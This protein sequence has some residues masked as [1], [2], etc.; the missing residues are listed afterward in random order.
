[1]TSPPKPG[2]VVVVCA[3]L[4]ISA[5]LVLVSG[6]L[7]AFAHWDPCSVFSGI[8]LLSLP[9]ALGLFQYQAV[10]RRNAKAARRA[11]IFL[12]IVAGIALLSL[13]TTTG[14]IFKARENP[15]S[16]TPLL[17]TMLVIGAINLLAGWLNLRW[18]RRLR[19]ATPPDQDETTGQGGFLRF[20]LRELLLV[21]T[22]VAVISGLTSY[23]V[24]GTLPRFAENVDRS[25]A[26][27]GLPPDA[28]SISYCQGYRG[29]IA[30]EFSID[31][32]GFRR[33]VNSGIGSFESEAANVPIRP[34]SEPFRIPRYYRLSPELV[35]P[36]FA[37]I[38]QGLYYSRSKED[39]GVDAVFD[40]ATNRAYYFAHFH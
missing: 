12:F 2:A 4:V 1:M 15:L 25:K 9:A 40:S 27:G 3:I 35:G 37:T 36:E 31:E 16:Y 8:L 19:A 5:C 7:S 28:T 17:L 21:V 13:V 20:S 24:R 22:V 32:D 6:C 26:P 18:S 33:W 38:T 23:F 39:R 34:I 30:Y 14:E 29:T 10:F 11:A